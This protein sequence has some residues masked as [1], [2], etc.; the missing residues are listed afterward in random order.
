V[1]TAV[2]RRYRF[3]ATHHVP[4]LPAPWNEPHEHD[5]TVE[6]VASLGIRVDVVVDTNI[7]DEWWQTLQ[8]RFNGRDLNETL[9]CMTTVESIAWWLLRKAPIDA[10]VTEVTVQEDD[11]R[12]GTACRQ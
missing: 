5:Y 12:S 4:S 2:A 6:V 3:R 8:S 11:D 10:A 7:I 1:R 9:P